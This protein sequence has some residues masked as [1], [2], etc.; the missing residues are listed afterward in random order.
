MSSADNRQGSTPPG[1]G[2]IKKPFTRPRI[3]AQSSPTV[4]PFV[5]N[6][7]PPF[8]DNR[9]GSTPPEQGLIKKPFMLPSSIGQPSPVG[10]PP[11]PR[12]AP[13][14]TG[15]PT[16]HVS[17]GVTRPLSESLT[18]EPNTSP[19]VTR[20]LPP[21]VTRPLIGEQMGMIP[22]MMNGT[23]SKRQPVVIPASGKKRPDGKGPDGKGPRRRRWY[24][25]MIVAIVMV[26]IVVGTLLSVV[27]IDNAGDHLFN[28]FQSISK[29][30][31][32]SGGNPSSLA[33]QDA[34]ATVT[35]QDGYDP[36]S[37]LVLGPGGALNHF[38]YGQ[39][40]Y[41]ASMRYH[42]L[43]GQWVPWL[44][45]AYQWA[46]EAP[47]FGWTVSP[48]PRAPSIIVLGPGVQGA[49]WFGHVAI[50]ES[51][52]PDGSV[53][54]SGW[55]WYGTYG[56]GWARLSVVTFRPGSGVSFVWHP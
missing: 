31:Q 35:H 24:M 30:V 33:Q 40:T 22:S 18:P 45:N 11:V 25:Q 4:Q 3:V 5:P 27:P 17:S 29:L 54:T 46:Y 21:A 50:V 1:Q 36:G 34:T 20:Q 14:S 39:C 44:G 48:T 47:G 16:Y 10:Q 12:T 19:H 6:V 56:G 9:Q 38:A 49:G 41:Y 7:V 37:G 26:V 23:T 55:N 42:Q 43:T 32:S 8:A 28:P 2:L 53:V 13:L 52:N 51:I 15:V